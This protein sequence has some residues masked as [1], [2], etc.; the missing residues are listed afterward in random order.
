MKLLAALLIALQA[1]P[2]SAQAPDAPSA[3]LVERFIAA[4]PDR[5]ALAAAGA[6]LDSTELARLSALNPGREAQLRAILRRNAGCT[7][8]VIAAGSLRVFRTIAGNL[9]EDGVRRLIAFYEG[10]DYAAF[11]AL[12][13]R[14]KDAPKPEAKDKA[15][16]DRL[17]RA[18][19]LDALNAQLG[20]AG[21]VFAAD[22]E[23]IGAVTKCVNEQRDAMTA[24]GLMSN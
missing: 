14:M 21:Q 3:A 10:P 17:M 11:A 6:E 4:L 13:A 23:F 5:E 8:P 15:A 2:A 18:Y 22:Q 19:P 7:G 9:G 20:Q 16:L 24:A 1:Q 12:A